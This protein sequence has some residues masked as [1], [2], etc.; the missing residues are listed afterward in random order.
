MKKKSCHLQDLSYWKVVNKTSTDCYKSLKSFSSWQA[1]LY[2]GKSTPGGDLFLLLLY[3][4]L[5]FSARL[6][7]ASLLQLQGFCSKLERSLKNVRPRRRG[8]S[9]DTHTI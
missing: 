5:R 9:Y 3:H 8:G 2:R 4:T 6:L 1:R 7:A